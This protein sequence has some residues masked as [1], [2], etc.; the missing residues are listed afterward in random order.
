MVMLEA[1]PNVSEGRDLAT[2]AAI[3]AALAGE[4]G[5]QLLDSSS[6]PDHHRSVFTAAGEPGPLERGL[7]AMARLAVE[8][9]DLGRH[10]GVHPRLGAVDVVPFVPLGAT[11]MADAIEAAERLGRAI[12][13]ELD[14]P[15]FLY[16]EAA[17][18]AARRLPVTLR[19]RGL[20]SVAAA[21]ATGELH[22]DYG[23]ARA[24]P[25][26][27][28]TLVGARTFLV[29]FN[30]WLGDASVRTAREIARAIRERDG[31][32]PG[33]QAM[34]FYLESRGRAQVSIKLVRPD[35]TTLEMVVERVRQEATAR[36][37]EVERGELIG[38]LPEAIASQT[39]AEALLLPELGAA[40]ILERR[41]SGLLTS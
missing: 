30:L 29:A 32:L 19:G 11:Q 9:I 3:A 17:R 18:D 4:P 24:H 25:T 21:L 5:V 8:R 16:G 14:V 34:G 39:T 10:C 6:D 41:L 36:G 1:V 28:V 7:L 12:G 23:P 13:E 31:G 2:V 37:V 35:S 26:A 38:L 33:V 20:S 15:V 40:Q 27:G 22:P